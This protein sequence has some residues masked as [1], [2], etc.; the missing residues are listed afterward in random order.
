MKREFV[1]CAALCCLAACAISPG[2]PGTIQTPVNGEWT[3]TFESSWGTMPIR[4]TLANEPY[5]QS[6]SGSYALDGQRAT[7]TIY[8]A[9]QTQ[10]KDGG[11]FLHGSMTISYQ[12]ADGQL[13]RSSSGVTSGSALANS[14]SMQTAGF[15]TGNCP[16]PPVTVRITL[17]R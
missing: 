9:L 17:H 2:S 7:G 15:P 5:S 11:G 1:T 4:M 10:E 13:C 8:G 12:M 14:F 6:I 16:E 3:G